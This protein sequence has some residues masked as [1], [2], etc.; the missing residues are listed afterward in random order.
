MI[1]EK[2]NDFAKQS[3][4]GLSTDSTYDGQTRRLNGERAG[5]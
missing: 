1:D 4:W 3:F 2:F 5:Q